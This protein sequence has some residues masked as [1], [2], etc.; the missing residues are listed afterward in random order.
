MGPANPGMK[1]VT[2][3]LEDF[4][5]DLLSSSL[6]YDH[7]ALCAWECVYMDGSGHRTGPPDPLHYQPGRTFRPCWRACSLSDKV[8][9]IIQQRI[10]QRMRQR[11]PEETKE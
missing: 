1:L 2:D 11:V 8:S 4:H 10:Q 7:P 3:A 5:Y 6:D 9:D